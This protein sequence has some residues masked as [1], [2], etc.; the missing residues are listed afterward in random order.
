MSRL[1]QNPLKNAKVDVN[2]SSESIDK[3]QS[4]CQN[5]R[6]F[7]QNPLKNAK[8]KVKLAE[9]GPET[10]LTRKSAKN[11]A[12]WCISELLG[13]SGRRVMADVNFHWWEA[14]SYITRN[15]EFYQIEGFRP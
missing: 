5:C 7:T 13:P 12:F 10:Y 8:A 9:L 15:P 3:C 4:Q 1:P 6:M 2:I 14:R 11:Y